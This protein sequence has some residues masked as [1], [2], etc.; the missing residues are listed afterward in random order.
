MCLFVYPPIG[1]K[2][3]DLLGSY[4][5]LCARVS[6]TPYLENCSSI[7]FLNI[8]LHRISVKNETKI[9]IFCVFLTLYIDFGEILPK[10]VGYGLPYYGKVLFAGKVHNLRDNLLN[11]LESNWIKNTIGFLCLVVN[12]NFS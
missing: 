2:L 3:V 7:F 10:I 12:S 6:V 1:F 5:L 9:N 8:A 4:R 11:P